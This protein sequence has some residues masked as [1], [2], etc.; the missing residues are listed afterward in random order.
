MSNTVAL[1]GLPSY[2]KRHNNREK[3]LYESIR[4][5]RNVKDT[6]EKAPIVSNSDNASGAAL[7]AEAAQGA[8]IGFRTNKAEYELHYAAVESTGTAAYLFP[9]Q[10]ADGLEIPLDADV[11]NGP[12]AVE[13][14]LGTTSRSKQAWTVGTDSFYLKATIKIDDISDLEELFLGFRKAEAYQADP[15]SYDEM[16]AF[17]IG[18]TGDTVAD[19]QINLATI[20]NNG[21]TDYTDTT[22]ADWADADEKT[23]EIRVLQ[24]GE[25]KFLIDG[26]EPTAS[27]QFRFDADEVVVPFLFVDNTSGST[28]G[29]PGV[30][31]SLL[32]CGAMADR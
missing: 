10:S 5:D 17:H 31:V 27:T 26:E 23:L 14:S 9:Y 12:T 1:K 11:T 28:T 13:V 8:E 24:T 29:D 30:S 15:D 22:E 3:K 6:F 21:T 32:E 19:G 25:V 4:E 7:P 2:P 16:A 20:L 18:E